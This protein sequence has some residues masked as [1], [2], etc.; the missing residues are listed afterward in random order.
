MCAQMMVHSY[1]QVEDSVVLPDVYVGRDVRLRRAIVDKYCVLPDGFCAGLDPAADAAR[2]R[3][4][5]G[6][7]VLV[8]PEMLGQPVG[9]RK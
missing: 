7:V 6:G 2:F 9:S 1:A 8:T 4:T 5:R 3:V